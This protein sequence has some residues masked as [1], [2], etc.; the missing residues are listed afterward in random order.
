MPTKNTSLSQDDLREVQD[1]IATV[2]AQDVHLGRALHLLQSLRPSRP[3]F[4]N[5]AT[6][7]LKRVYPVIW[8]LSR[9]RGA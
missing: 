7:S 1:A 6:R 8:E 9:G 4:H 2:A 5:E 3:D